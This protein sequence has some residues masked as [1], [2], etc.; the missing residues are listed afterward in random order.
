MEPQRILLTLGASPLELSRP[1]CF[2]E[3]W[4]LGHLVADVD[5][6]LKLGLDI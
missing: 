5:N 4:L 6:F 1:T 2:M 3:H